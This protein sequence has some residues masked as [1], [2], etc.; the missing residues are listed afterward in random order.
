MSIASR[1]DRPIFVIGTGRCGSTIIFEA[2]AL[3]EDLGW[4]SNYNEKLPRVGIV[5]V[6]PRI[7][8][9]PLLSKVLPRGEKPQFKQGQSR[10]NRLLPKP[11]ECY[12]KWELMCG[13]KFRDDYLLG[14]EATEGEKS[15][16]ARS[17]LQVLKLQGKPRFAAKIT[18]PPR[19]SYLSSIFPDARFVHII[20]EGKAVVN[21]W[22][23]VDFWKE[24][25]SYFEPRWKNG[26]PATWEDE[27]KSYGSTPAALAAIQYRNI[28]NVSRQEK[29]KLAANQYLEV[30]YEAFIANPE[31]V[32]KTIL[33]FCQLSH[34]SR[35][36]SYISRPG[37]YRNMNDKVSK[38]FSEQDLEALDALLSH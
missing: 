6:L 22:L 12:P 36:L 29:A 31:A 20:R 5:S 32:M 11:S 14:V 38:A 3:H 2:L 28:L 34:S 15:R 25:S 30:S 13:R 24:S 9:L 33:D 37:R 1:I 16:V 10:L 23:N 7:Y 21:S 19:I 8:D 35:V 27:W 4:F 26:L 17:V 18:G